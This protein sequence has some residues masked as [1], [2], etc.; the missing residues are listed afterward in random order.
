MNILELI[1][2][3]IIG[4]VVVFFSVKG[5]KKTAFR[6]SAFVA[7]ILL[8]KLIGKKVGHFLLSNIVYAKITN[9]NIEIS[10]GTGDTI[11]SALGTLT[12]FLLLFFILKKIF[13]VVEGKMKPSL[14]SVIAERIFGASGLFENVAFVLTFMKIVMLNFISVTDIK[15]DFQHLKSKDNSIIYRFARI[16]N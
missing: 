16:L 8:A 12:V 1:G 14:Q 13:A 2:L 11:I 15:R 7:I 10:E 4:T 6:I 9:L 3:V 5:L